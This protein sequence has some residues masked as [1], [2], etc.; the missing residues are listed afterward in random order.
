MEYT[1]R[2][3]VNLSLPSLRIDNFSDELLEKISK[4]RKS[5]L[6][7]A[8]E[9]GTQRLRDIINK[10]VT[11]DEV[12]SSCKISFEGG[13]TSVKLYFMLGLPGETMED[14]EGIIELAQKVVDLFYS[15]P[16][17]KRQK[18]GVTVSVSAST[19][20]PKPFT[21]FQWEPQA[22]GEQ[23]TARQKHMLEVTKTKK[24]RLNWHNVNT[25]VLEAVLARGDRRLCKVIYEAWKSGC[26]F[27]SWDEHFHFDLW[28]RAMDNAG[29]NMKFYANRKRDYSEILPWSHIDVGVSAEFLKMENEKAKQALTTPNCRQKCSACSANKLIGGACFG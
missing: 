9:A 27:D 5:G 22:T 16:K 1:D 7:F 10:N 15:I 3:K 4:V 6:T 29:L 11:E 8:P 23:I 28:Q 24:I 13:Y 12:L 21:P 20:V 17:H 2:E 14:I 26:Y 25:S 18:G 19:F